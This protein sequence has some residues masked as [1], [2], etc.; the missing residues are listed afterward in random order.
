M[1]ET[2]G[3]MQEVQAYYGACIL[4]FMGA[5]HWGLAMADQQQQ[6]RSLIVRYSLSCVPPL[7]S[8]ASLL[9][10]S[11]FPTADPALLMQLTGFLALSCYDVWK[12][13]KGRDLIPSWYPLLRIFLTTI[14]AGSI[15]TTVIT[16]RTRQKK[17]MMN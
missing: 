5:V 13:G 11:H 9:S 2:I 12:G 6:S 17:K 8:F 3:L 10:L 14:V 1:P 15:A 16:S 4:S 7:V